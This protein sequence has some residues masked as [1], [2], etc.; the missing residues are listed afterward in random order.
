MLAADSTASGASVEID[1]R[2]YDEFPVRLAREAGSVTEV[3]SDGVSPIFF[4]AWQR[5][6]EENPAPASEGFAVDTRLV[7]AAL[8][9]VQPLEEGRSV[10]LEARI[11]VEADAD[12]VMIEIPIP[13]GMAYAS[14]QPRS[15]YETYRERYMERTSIFC[16]RLP[17]GRHTF[18]VDLVPR[19]A[20]SYAVEAARAELMYYPTR[21]GRNASTRC[22]I[23]ERDD[24]AG[25]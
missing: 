13:A 5:R 12:Y 2:R 10:R 17:R 24:T 15:R 19:Y 20:G 4:T 9:E 7:D 8:G 1:G 3:V 23:V 14:E 22:R 16:T 11:D 18:T 21:C 6:R 25:K